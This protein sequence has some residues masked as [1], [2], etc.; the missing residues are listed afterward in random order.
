MNDF[1][2]N[3]KFFCL[4]FVCLIF[5]FSIAQDFRTS[6]LGYTD[7]VLNHAENSLNLYRKTGNPAQMLQNEPINWLKIYGTGSY[8]HGDFKRQYDPQAVQN[9]LFHAE[10]FK[11]LG[12][13]QGF[14]GQVNYTFL[15]H[16][17]LPFAVEPHPYHDDPLVMTDSTIGSYN[18]DGP[19]IQ[20]AY[21]YRLSERLS[22]GAELFYEISQGLKREFTRPRILQRDFAAKIAANFYAGKAVSI[23]G[24]YGYLTCNDLI[25]FET[26]R[27]DGMSPQVNR[28]RSES[29]YRQ[30]TGNFDR[31]VEIGSHYLNFA[32]QHHWEAA[33]LQQLI[34]LN[35]R[36]Y[37][38]ET[39]DETARKIYD[40]DWFADFYHLEYE[41][42]KA[43]PENKMD[44]GVRLGR[45][46]KSSWS[47]HPELPILITEREIQSFYVELGVS[48]RFRFK[49]PVLLALQGGFTRLEDDYNDYQSN[50]FRDLTEKLWHLHS[51]V[52]LQLTPIHRLQIGYIYRN[53]ETDVF[54]PR[55]L[56]DYY[57]QRI[58]LGLTQ[59]RASHD[60]T[61]LWEYDLKTSRS[62]G[63]NYGGW[64]LTIY[65]RILP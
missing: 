15:R 59:V 31:Y 56:P 13:K 27:I 49:K 65:S 61:I 48:H 9:I 4:I 10:G 25:E 21:Q 57:Q 40:S 30:V 8:Y 18:Y 34:Q 22:L 54:S 46:Y 12:A 32:A 62:A 51:G 55:Y 6:A 7:L 24:Q 1:F 14:W 3:R 2:G 39:F 23:G 17:N 50:I 11:Q 38:Q 16:Y 45:K 19:Q 33:N 63:G 26:S 5:A 64:Q 53:S 43:T 36:N 35:Y 58:S 20:V 52:E 28:F 44:W 42:R 41:I 37:G 60:I 29:V 47:Q